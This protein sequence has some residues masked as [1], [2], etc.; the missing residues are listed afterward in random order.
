[1]ADTEN[2]SA[3]SEL[4]A[5]ALSGRI[6]RRGFMQGALALGLGVTA[7]SSLW[8]REVAAATPK[9]G[10]TFRV[11]LDDGNTSDTLDPTTYNSRFMITMAHTRNNF[12]TEIAP[13][14]TVTGELAE[15][16]EASKDAKTWTL[17]LRKGVEFHN[18]KTFD[19]KDAAASLNLH[20]GAQSKSAAKPLLSAI[21]E[22]KVDDNNTLVLKLKQGNADIPFALT[23]Y[24]LIMLPLGKDGKIDP[25][26]NAGTGGYVLDSFEPGVRATMKRF[27]NYWKPDKAHFDEVDFTAANDVV[28]RQS[29]LQST[30]FDAIIECDYNTV[31]LMAQDDGI[32]VDEVPSG[33]HVGMPMFCDAK[34]FS[35]LDLRMALKL[36]TD[37]EQLM[38]RVLKGHGSIGNDQ[39][40]APTM[41]FYDAG[42]KQRPYDPDQ[43]RALI[44]KAGL[45]GLT[46]QL[47]A[48]DT[49]IT[50][51]TDMAVLF[52]EMAKKIGV[53]VE[54][55]REVNDSY[56][57]DV[58][59]KKPFC[60]AGWGQRP[61][62]DIIFSLGYAK[63]ADWNESHFDNDRFN[64]L[65][66][67]ARAEIETK[68]RAEMYGEM[69]RIVSDKG[70]TIIPFFRNWIYAR[71]SNV[72]HGEKLSASW[73]LDGARGAERWWFA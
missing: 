55:K 73:P 42:Q 49:V 24:H 67:E 51:A 26:D 59:L 9:K 20:R 13:D 28:A 50:G 23:D 16:L 5:H 10:G 12:L 2:K 15:S 63:G 30:T 57:S 25:L 17:K 41:P 60:M 19:A 32:K 58:W 54:V 66:I 46:I 71:R 68:K 38:K 18:G 40:I 69:Q 11:G 31:D 47:S 56:W 72:M 43:A 44:K 64:K 33:T 70:G 14:N 8:T 27:A 48:A 45:D 4:K 7:A 29:A 53:N 21:D 37:R 1:M 3:L 62:P 22:I 65:L 34:P 36:A 35:N 39:P 6:N 52:A 61:T